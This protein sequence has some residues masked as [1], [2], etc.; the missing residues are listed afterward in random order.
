MGYLSSSYGLLTLLFID[1]A[2]SCSLTSVGTSVTTLADPA[3]ARFTARNR[4]LYLWCGANP[5]TF[6][7]DSDSLCRAG[8]CSPS[9]AIFTKFCGRSSRQLPSVVL[10]I[11]TW[12]PSTGGTSISL[13]KESSKAVY[14]IASF[15]F[16]SLASLFLLVFDGVSEIHAEPLD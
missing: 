11:S 10:Q 4:M 13:R 3:P 15:G 12:I 8:T 1:S 9:S 5:T 7:L 14:W 16:S 2:G 6:V